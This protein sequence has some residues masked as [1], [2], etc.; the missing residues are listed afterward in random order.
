[1]KILTWKKLLLVATKIFFFLH[2]LVSVVA[3]VRTLWW[4]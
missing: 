1:M 2:Y 3:V 4:C